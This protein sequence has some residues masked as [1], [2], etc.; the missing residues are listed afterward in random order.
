MCYYNSKAF[1]SGENKFSE[2]DG[3]FD[4]AS[5]IKENEGLLKNIPFDMIEYYHNNINNT[6]VDSKDYDL[7]VFSETFPLN[8][9]NFNSFDKDEGGSISLNEEEKNINLLKIDTTESIISFKKSK[10]VNSLNKEKLEEKEEPNTKE[11]GRDVKVNNVNSLVKY[12][13]FNEILALLRIS[14]KFILQWL[15]EDYITNKDKKSVGL[16]QTPNKKQ[17]LQSENEDYITDKDKKSVDLFQ[18]PNKKQKLQSASQNEEKVKGRKRKRDN[19]EEEFNKNIV[20]NQEEEGKK[21]HNKFAQD[22]IIK[23]CKGIF[24]SNVI[25]KLNYEKYVKD[26]KKENELNL[27]NTSLKKLASFEASPKYKSKNENT[28]NNSS[29]IEKILNKEKGN[30]KL[31]NLLNLKFG[32]WLDIFLL[33]N[34][35]DDNIEFNGLNSSL[36]KV[37]KK[38]NSPKYLS[39]FVFLLFNYKRWFINKKGRNEGL[40]ENNI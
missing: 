21:E 2:E 31:E 22:N 25:D 12:Y 39:R 6:I 13:N 34:K 35:F 28:I 23:K 17:K 18:T 37:R 10:E 26:L 20:D 33:K 16:F 24:F 9:N 11:N 4:Q 14:C 40:Q 29:K 1:I 38:N 5:M 15:N 8:E 3:T 32:D 7:K 19:Y 27:F 36:E 30:N